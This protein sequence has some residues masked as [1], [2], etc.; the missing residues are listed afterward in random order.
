MNG[1]PNLYIVGA[2]KSATTYTASVLSASPDI[3]CPEPKELHYFASKYISDPLRRNDP[4]K[5]YDEYIIRDN[6]K[7]LAF[8]NDAGQY[9]FQLDASP[10]NLYYEG[11]AAD[12]KAISPDARIIILLRNPVDR[13][14]SQYKMNVR[15]GKE[16]LSF[17][18]A[19][20]AENERIGSGFFM[21]TAYLKAGHYCNSVQEYLDVFG[22]GN[23][24]IVLFDEIVINEKATF[25]EI[26]S[27]LDIEFKDSFLN[28]G[29]RH[30]T[31]FPR[32]RLI[33]NILHNPFLRKLGKSLIMG[34][35]MRNKLDSH[36]IKWN[37]SNIEMDSDTRKSLCRYF[38]DDISKLERATGFDLS[39]WKGI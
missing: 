33:N 28:F 11:C 23:V 24:H 34:R 21:A 16:K 36:M 31:G 8:F 29:D 12:I 17:E 27:F 30:Y 14:F 10:S 38:S 26:F 32:N 1:F 4:F 15:L 22:T 9:S 5:S 13:A 3:F 20:K 2:A 7:Y 18:E 19:L 39:K 25:D 35:N 37:D 6:E